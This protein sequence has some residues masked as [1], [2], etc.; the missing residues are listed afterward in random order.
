M[1]SSHRRGHQDCGHTAQDDQTGQKSEKE[2]VRVDLP[3]VSLK[4]RCERNSLSHK[5]SSRAHF[6]QDTCFLKEG[7]TYDQ[8]QTGQPNGD[9]HILASKCRG[10]RNYHHE[11]DG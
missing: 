9:H 3:G 6:P 1:H 7:N 4:T 11:S 8:E 10:T 2:H 5:G